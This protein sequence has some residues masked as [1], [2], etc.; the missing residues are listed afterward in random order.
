MAESELQWR[1]PEFEERSK[2]ISW[3]WASIIAA[4]L[5]LGFALWQKNFLFAVFILI[6]EL[7]L[8]VW[9]NRAPQAIHFSLDATTLTVGGKSRYVLGDME[10][11]SIVENTSAEWVIVT[12]HPK[13]GVRLPVAIHAPKSQ[14]AEIEKR[15]AAKMPKVEHEESFLDTL[16]KFLG[17]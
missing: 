5:I 14:I 16:E 8:L 7:L 17:F 10:H 4:I 6:A 15:L 12:L 2:D 3:Y 1:A 11:F 13:R 9:G